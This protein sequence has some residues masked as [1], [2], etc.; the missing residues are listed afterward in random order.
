[1]LAIS[2]EIR[3]LS[4]VVSEVAFTA[5][6]FFTANKVA[7]HN[8]MERSNCSVFYYHLIRR[9]FSSRAR[10]LLDLVIQGE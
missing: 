9:L 3:G 5:G 2:P 7:Q 8:Y 10:I 6:I 4:V 1:M